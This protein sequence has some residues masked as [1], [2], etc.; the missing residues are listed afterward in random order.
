ML[1][2]CFGGLRAVVG[3]GLFVTCSLRA[4]GHELHVFGDDSGCCFQVTLKFL[5]SKYD[6]RLQSH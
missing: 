5:V 2:S 4:V 6:T 3:V 1:F